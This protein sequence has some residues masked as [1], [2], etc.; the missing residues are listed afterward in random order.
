MGKSEVITAEKGC[1][2]G[3]CPVTDKMGLTKLYFCTKGG[4]AEQRGMSM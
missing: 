3:G 1:T 2:C 4:E